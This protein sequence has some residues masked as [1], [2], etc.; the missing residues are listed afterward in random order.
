MFNTVWMEPN[1]PRIAITPG[2]PSG[3]GPDLCLAL[4]QQ[5]H[6]A[7]LVFIA[8]P[9]LLQR[10]AE[11]LGIQVDI[12]LYEAN[13]PSPSPSQ[14]NQLLVKPVP[15]AATVEAG[16]L[17]ID[18]SHYVLEC[19]DLACDGCVEGEFSAMVTG[20]IQKSAIIEAGHNFSGHTEYLAERTLAYPV[21]MLAN[22]NLRV[23]LVT[24][25]L[26]LKD[27]P[28]AITPDVLEQTL[29][30]VDRDLKQR[31]GIQQ[32]NIL[33]CGLNPHAGEGGHL[34]MEEKTLIEPVLEQLKTEMNVFGPVP[35]DTAFSKDNIANMDVFVAMFHDQGLPVI[36]ALGFGE[37]VNVTL[38]LP[39][40][41]TSVDH[42]TAL[43]LA[44]TG[45]ADHNSFLAALQMAIE[46]ATET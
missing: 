5:A 22:A 11:L 4:S 26:P 46:L 18:N 6:P 34:G 12:L 21:M 23:A 8:D 9:D 2:E 40:I 36:K 28:Q 3:I 27:V 29:R 32:P 17:N 20:P 43:A 42:G 45:K 37:T 38:G 19:L 10:R 15:L 13:S 41:R 35:A 7:E 24:T 30:L 33:V 25:H 16:K 31:F 1:C 14:A 39:I 44:G